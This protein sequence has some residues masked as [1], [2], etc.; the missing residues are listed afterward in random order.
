MKNIGSLGDYWVET[1]AIAEWIAVLGY[2]L[3]ESFDAINFLV[4]LCP[5][6]EVVQ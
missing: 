2:K 6:V 5:A 4:L 3:P 1:A